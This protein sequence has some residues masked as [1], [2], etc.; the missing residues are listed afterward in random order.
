MISYKRVAVF[1]ATYNGAKYL[2]EQIDSILFQE[3]IG[4]DIFVRD[5][6][7]TDE[8]I[9]ILEEYSLEYR[10]FYILK[11][12][13]IQ[14]GPGR[15]FFSILNEIDLSQYDFVSYCDQDDKWLSN[16]LDEAVNKIEA[17]NVNCYGSNLYI[18][19]GSNV[20]GILNKAT[21][22][23]EYDFLFESASAGCTLVIDRKSANYLKCEILKNFEKFP[24]EIS[25]D[26]FTYA[27]TRIGGFK[28]FLDDRAFIY[29]RQHTSNQY[30]ANR[31]I[32]GIKK[33]LK[34]FGSGW[35]LSNINTIINLFCHIKPSFHFLLINY[36]KLGFIQRVKLAFIV[37]KFRRKF[38]HKFYLF[39]LFIF[40]IIK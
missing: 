11:P 34:L 31:G 32:Q 10:N 14:L 15:N 7:S 28:W 37:F 40:K 3:K 33:L 2:R 30:G 39:F 35:Y 25:H 9:S 1:L 13:G 17:E 8:T 27:I 29:Y 12:I 23:T 4:V 19:D 22:Q 20:T 6:H 26:W 16:K 36:Y 24:F 18:W 21:V 38:Q 5:D